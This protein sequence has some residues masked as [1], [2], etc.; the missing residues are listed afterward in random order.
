M[1]IAILSII[2][3]LFIGACKPLMIH[4]S[5]KIAP[6]FGQQNYI[7]RYLPHYFDISHIKSRNDTVIFEGGS[8][9]EFD[10]GEV[11]INTVGHSGKMIFINKKN[12]KTTKTLLFKTVEPPFSV[13]LDG[14]ERKNRKINME[15]IANGCFAVTILNCD[16]D[17]WF[18]IREVTLSTH[19][20]STSEKSRI[21]SESACLSATQ[22]EKLRQ[23]PNLSP[24]IFY[25]TIETP[26]DTF[27][28]LDPIVMLIEK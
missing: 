16:I 27:K 26:T 6:S 1:K 11:R 24:A 14:K 21:T 18:K 2:L 15:S 19:D 4:R 22:R 25:I 5:E 7:I 17:L 28:T 12:N 9:E 20:S 3:I 10:N 13:L 23:L 8:I